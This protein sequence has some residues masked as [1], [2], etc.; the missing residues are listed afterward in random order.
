[1]MTAIILAI[2]FAPLSLI[3][4]LFVIITSPVWALI[5]AAFNLRTLPGPLMLV[6]T[7]DDDIYGSKTT[8]DPVPSSFAKRFKRAVWWLIR[9]PGYG[10]DAY[11]LGYPASDV[12]WIDR[13]AKTNNGKWKG[14]ELAYAIDF[15][16]LKGARTRFGLRANVPLIGKKYIKI[17]IGWH[18]TDQ[19]GR[20]MFKFDF[21]PFKTVGS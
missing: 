21:N 13:A 2:L 19:A 8:G 10:F 5:A 9:N 1:M 16:H 3:F 7:H 6:H 4:N 11:V 17:W 14:V 12:L 15:L 20:H 18:A